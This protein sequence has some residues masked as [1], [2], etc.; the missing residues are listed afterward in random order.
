MFELNSIFV[1]PK[2]SRRKRLLAMKEAAFYDLTRI[3]ARMLVIRGVDDEAS[4]AL[5]AGAIASRLS[6]FLLFVGIPTFIAILAFLMGLGSWLPGE[7]KIRPLLPFIVDGAAFGAVL[8]LFLPGLFKSVFGREFL[9]G[10]MVCEI[11]TDSVPDTSS[12]LNAITLPPAS[13]GR[14]RHGIY[15]HEDCVKQIVDWLRQTE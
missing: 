3:K 14:L 1:N 4:L 12:Q 10:G 9:I 13:N 5:A 11:A 8:C 7:D 15:N 2:A 6:N